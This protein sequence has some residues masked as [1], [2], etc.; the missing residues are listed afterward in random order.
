METWSIPGWMLITITVVIAVKVIT[1]TLLNRQRK[2]LA[3][4]HQELLAARERLDHCNQRRQSAES[5]MSFSERQKT[6]LFRRIELCTQELEEL[7]TSDSGE[8]ADE[9]ADPEVP[10]HMRTRGKDPFGER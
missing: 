8:G 2:Q 4:I 9:R 5:V 6:D 1:G 10:L 7:T 3:G